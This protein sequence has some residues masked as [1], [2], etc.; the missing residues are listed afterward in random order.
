VTDC[1][2]LLHYWESISPQLWGVLPQRA[3]VSG[4][5]TPS[6]CNSWVHVFAFDQSMNP[7][8]TN[9]ITDCGVPADQ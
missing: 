4:H 7:S 5:M 9:T 2:L 1:A 6:S 8:Q 3:F